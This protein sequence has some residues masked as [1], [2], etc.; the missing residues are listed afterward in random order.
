MKRSERAPPRPGNGVQ[1]HALP[2]PLRGQFDITGDCDVLFGMQATERPVRYASR[3]ATRLRD[4][5][6]NMASAIE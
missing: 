3:A 4:A 2:T 6:L 5:C 1:R